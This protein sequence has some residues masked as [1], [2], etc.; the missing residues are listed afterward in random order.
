MGDADSL[1]I[2]LQR[3]RDRRTNP[4]K[5]F[6]VNTVVPQTFDDYT[7]VVGLI[8]GLVFF[9]TVFI[10]SSGLVLADSIVVDD[11]LSGTLMDK[12]DCVDKT[13]EVWLQT[14]VNQD[15]DLRLRTQ[16]VQ[17]D[18]SSIIL[19]NLTNE[20]GMVAHST[21]LGGTGDHSLTVLHD[22]LDDGSFE[23]AM[24]VYVLSL[25]HI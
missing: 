23:V 1:D 8:S 13:G 20:S 4:E 3:I 6:M 22:E 17:S 14:W 5:N 21:I 18:S 24:T 12:S 2:E 11:T 10:A 25:I 7:L 15:Q 9:G 19:V 16:N